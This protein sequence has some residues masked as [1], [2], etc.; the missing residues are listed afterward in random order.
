[1]KKLSARASEIDWI[2]SSNL[3]DSDEAV[4][5]LN[6]NINKLLDEFAPIQSKKIFH[7]NIHPHWYTPQIIKLIDLKNF[8]RQILRSKPRNKSF[9]LNKI[10]KYN[11]KIIALKRKLKLKLNE[12]LYLHQPAKKLWQNFRNQ[13]IVDSGNLLDIDFNANEINQYF[14]DAFSEKTEVNFEIIA[15]SK[16][17]TMADFSFNFHKL[18]E[19]SVFEF[20]MSITSNAIG[21]DNIPIKF[22]KMLFPFIVP[23]LTNIINNSIS[24]SFFPNPWKVAKVIPI[25][26]NKCP[27]SLEDIRAISVLPCLSKIEEKA[28]HFQMMN[29]FEDNLLL[30]EMQSGF[31]RFRGCST[32][33]MKINYDIRSQLDKGKSCM[34]VLLDFRKAFDLVPHDILINKLFYRY[35]FSI[36]AAKLVSSYLANRTQFVFYRNIASDDVKVTS[37]VPQGG[38]KSSLLFTI[39]INDLVSYLRSI[40]PDANFHLY[41]DDTQIYIFF[42]PDKVDDAIDQMNLILEA[43]SRWCELNQVIINAKKSHAIIYSTAT[44]ISHN[45]CKINGEIIEMCNSVRNLGLHMNSKLS[46]DDHID[47]VV[48]N[49]YATLRTLNQSKHEIPFFARL[50]LAKSLIVPHMN[51]CL[52]VFC[53]SKFTKKLEK[54]IRATIRYVFNKKRSDSVSM[55]FKDLLKCN[56]IDAFFKIHACIFLFKLLRTK[57]P[58]YLYKLIN[59]PS[60]PR[61]N[62]LYVPNMKSNFA[63]DDFFYSTITLWNSLDSDIRCELSPERFK[64]KLYDFFK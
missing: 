44:L 20:L 18:S 10:K 57:K 23:P 11:N 59:F 1:M 46:Y 21:V 45:Y 47:K 63:R 3:S 7:N 53:S 29:Y 58:D 62:S 19:H 60:K 25:A 32:A 49:M 55:H 48:S 34:M 43:T 38:I 14:S 31:R 9:H 42:D 17:H 13:G 56:S 26:K 15:A 39:F 30:D 12:K 61:L 4:T 22:A 5:N 35:N 41:A 52:G 51:F 27:S 24:N 40:F 2:T 36:Q 6:A 37:G 64:K 33:L 16:Q 8:H 28:L 54:P 50:Q